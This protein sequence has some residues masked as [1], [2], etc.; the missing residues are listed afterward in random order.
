LGS[1]PS[2]DRENQIKLWPRNNCSS[3]LCV[4]GRF[5]SLFSGECLL[6]FT[7]L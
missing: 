1:S 2:L 6:V 4:P 3:A 5:P 7:A